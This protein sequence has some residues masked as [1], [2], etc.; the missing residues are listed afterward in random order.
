MV[1]DG[2]RRLNPHDRSRRNAEIVTARVQGDSWAK[3]EQRFDVSARQA[4]RIVKDL[5]Y[6]D[7]TTA[8]D[9]VDVV[10]RALDRCEANIGY[11]SAVAGAAKNHGLILSAIEAQMR[12]TEHELNLLRDI[13]LL[14]ARPSNMAEYTR[15]QRV[16]QRAV[17]VL[18][19]HQVPQAAR[20]DL[21]S[22]L[23]GSSTPGPLPTAT[24]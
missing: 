8:L 22:V 4:R 6:A 1:G 7:V 11:L 3:I 19:R 12:V 10:V 14:P 9:S 21:M 24:Q 13:G 23:R 17:E 15:K 16:V 18:E 5:G 20:E 2:D